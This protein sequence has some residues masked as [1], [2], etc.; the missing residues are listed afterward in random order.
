LVNHG[1]E[2]SLQTCLSTTEN[3][4]MNVMGPFVGVDDL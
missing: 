4:G 1:L 2:K 3:K